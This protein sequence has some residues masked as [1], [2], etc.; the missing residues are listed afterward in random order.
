M[1]WNKT[2]GQRR[3]EWWLATT[4]A[5]GLWAIIFGLWI[6]MMAT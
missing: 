3:L 4:I 1:N 5:V 2:P 6:W